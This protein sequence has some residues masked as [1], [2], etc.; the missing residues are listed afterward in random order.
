KSYV[1]S[2]RD[3][4]NTPAFPCGVTAIKR[5][6][7]W[8]QS[9]GTGH[10]FCTA[11]RGGCRSIGHLQQR[12]GVRSDALHA[13][14][15]GI[16][17]GNEY[18]QL[19]LCAHGFSTVWIGSIVSIP[20]RGNPAGDRLARQRGTDSADRECVVTN[21]VCLWVVL[22]KWAA[23]GWTAVWISAVGVLSGCPELSRVS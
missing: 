7:D 2:T 10:E 15:G 1:L 8:G 23:S 22:R 21:V 18:E 5:L 9:C 13:G 11:E 17:R 12:S 19:S 4:N 16:P 3:V 6:P 14:F 20:R